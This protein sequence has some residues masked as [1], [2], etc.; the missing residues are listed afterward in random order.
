MIPLF[1]GAIPLQFWLNFRHLLVCMC[2]LPA[3][4]MHKCTLIY[5]FLCII[6]SGRWHIQEC[7][8]NSKQSVLVCPYT[9]TSQDKIEKPSTKQDVQ[10]T[11]VPEKF[12]KTFSFISSLNAPFPV[13]CWYILLLASILSI[14]TH[15]LFFCYTF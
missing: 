3:S 9:Q 15:I 14:Y 7:D 12:L 8:K 13:I 1:G 6:D 2:H 4:I 11:P 5:A 10:T